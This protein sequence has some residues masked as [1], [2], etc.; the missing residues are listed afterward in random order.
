MFPAGRLAP[1]AGVYLFSGRWPYAS[2]VEVS[3]WLML[4]AMATRDREDGPHPRIVMVRAADVEVIDT[5]SVAGLCGTGSHDVACKNV[6]VPDH[7]VL[8]PL[9]SR[10]G[11]T[12]GT[13]ALADAYKLPLIPFIPHLVAA[14]MIGLARAARPR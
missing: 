1:V 6:F 10:E 5:W 7:M 3:D 11:Y 12:P 4:G 14:P 8:D 13:E 2:G 9:P